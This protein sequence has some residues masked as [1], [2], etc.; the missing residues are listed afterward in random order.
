ERG[1]LANA[2]FLAHAVERDL[3]GLHLRLRRLDIGFRRIEL[4]PRL[5]HV[6][7]NLVA[8]DVEIE[9]PRPHRL[10]GLPDQRIFRTTLIDR[11]RELADH[12]SAEGPQLP[13]APLLRAA[14]R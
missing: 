2:R 6:L 13:Q 10:L 5:P 14:E 12:R 4:A 7:A 3:G 11:H 8:R 1:A 9:T